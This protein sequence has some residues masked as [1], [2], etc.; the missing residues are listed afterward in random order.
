M[1]LNQLLRNHQLAKRNAESAHSQRERTT[2]FDLVGYYAKRI[3]A[4]RRAK[5]VAEASWKP[6]E[7]RRGSDDT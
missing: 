1:D 2:Y 5:G 3:T 4:W 7:H 6:D